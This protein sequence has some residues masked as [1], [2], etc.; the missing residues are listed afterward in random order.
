MSEGKVDSVPVSIYESGDL[1]NT[2]YC[3][4]SYFMSDGLTL[5]KEDDCNM[6]NVLV[7]M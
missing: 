6:V 2:L 4:S 3:N 1:H 5:V 7:P